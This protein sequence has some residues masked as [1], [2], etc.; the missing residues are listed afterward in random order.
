MQRSAVI[1]TTA[2]RFG[3]EAW[4][5]FGLTLASVGWASA[6]I[7]G[8]VVLAE[9]T[10][11]PAAASR[12]LVATAVLLPL[13]WGKWPSRAALRPVLA[14]LA[15]M[16]VCGG[17]LYQWIFLLALERTSAT[18][19]SLLV[20]LNPVFTTLLSPLAGERLERGR[21]GGVLLA[22]A[23]AALVITRGQLAQ[24][25]DLAGGGPNS[26][27]VLAVAGAMCWASFNVASRRVVHIMS[28]ASINTLIYGTGGIVLGLFSLRDHPWQ[29]LS[30]ASAA[31]W[32]GILVMSIG[33]SVLAGHLF[34]IG[35]RTVGVSRT[36]VFVYFV[37]VLTAI[38]SVF[39]L[40]EAFGWAQALGGAAVLAGVYWTT[41]RRGPAAVATS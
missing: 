35:V 7:A 20:A 6:F 13:A 37:P 41:Q 3:S 9:V 31:A 25:G 33:S 17:L 24:I 19:A 4:A 23:G 38:A 28:P 36:V 11:L 40:G 14:Q 15:V 8:K 10:P 2:P 34:L 1:A 18:N 26:G 27:D 32:C 22:L 29:Q 12:Y 21:L 30:H 39:W 16:I 5:Y